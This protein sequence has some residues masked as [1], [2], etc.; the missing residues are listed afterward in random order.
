MQVMTRNLDG[1]SETDFFVYIKLGAEFQFE[2]EIPLDLWYKATFVKFSTIFQFSLTD[3]TRWRSGSACVKT[4][5]NIYGLQ[6]TPP[7][8]AHNPGM[9]EPPPIIHNRNPNSRV[10]DPGSKPGVAINFFFCFYS[11][12]KSFCPCFGQSF[13][14]AA[15]KA[16][17]DI[18]FWRRSD[19]RKKSSP[20]FRRKISNYSLLAIKFTG[21]SVSNVAGQSSPH[22][23]ITLASEKRGEVIVCK[24]QNQEFT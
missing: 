3:R 19:I 17:A 7:G 4:F 22:S 15:E 12:V 8:R 23:R 24:S 18:L 16:D 14:E 9:F 1:A 2:S 13:F 5:R 10:E 11:D 6:L 21:C 20:S